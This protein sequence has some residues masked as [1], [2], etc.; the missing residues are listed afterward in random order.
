M[1][2]RPGALLL[3]IEGTTT[4]I[5]FVYTVLFPYAA[6]ATGG[7]LHRHA[8]DPEALAALDAL[9]AEHRAE[10]PDARDLPPWNPGDPAQ[11]ALA[12]V[13]HLMDAD[14]KSTALKQLQGLVWKE[15]YANGE[16]HGEVYPDVPPALDRCREARIPVYIYS[17]GSVLAQ[18]LLFS[19]TRAGD[20]TPHFAG[21]F[22]TTTGPK[23]DPASY[24]RIAAQVGRPAEAILFVSDNEKE[25]VAAREAGMA[26]LL[27][28]RPGNPPASGDWPSV[29]SFDELPV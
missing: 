26:V 15:G 21:Y 27:S 17:S 10:A 11:S 3:D 16:L 5:D 7:F 13:R 24:T 8:A 23:L 18:K 22:D 9:H 1:P 14:R 12:Y 6:K 29:T 28:V 4:P 2:E 25:L 20:L 19:T